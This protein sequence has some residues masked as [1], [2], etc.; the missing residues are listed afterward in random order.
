MAVFF[1]LSSRASAKDLKSF[2]RSEK[3]INLNTLFM[4]SDPSSLRSSG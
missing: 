4:Y 3:N 1:I 2:E